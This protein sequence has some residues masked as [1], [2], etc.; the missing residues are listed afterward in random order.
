MDLANLD[1]SSQSENSAV[2]TIEHP[3]TLE[4]F[5]DVEGNP[6]TITFLGMDSA[7]A[8]R[9]TKARSQQALN[10]R[11]IKFD[12]DDM[13]AQTIELLAKLVVSSH[14]IKLNGEVYDLAD[15]TTAKECFTKYDWLREQ[16]DNF[17]Q[18]RS[19]F[20]KA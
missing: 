20:C 15:E 1:L 19:N 5:V 2:M 6:V 9:F 13:R 12:I 10:K 8:K 17:V 4:E 16:A 3:I 11:R 14:G 18:E 7:V